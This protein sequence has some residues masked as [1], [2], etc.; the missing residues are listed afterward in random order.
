[1]RKLHR[2][3]EEEEKRRLKSQVYFKMRMR[4]GF[5]MPTKLTWYGHGCWA[6]ESSGYHVLIDPFLNDSPVAPVKADQ[7]AADYILISHGHFDHIADAA[8]IAQRTGAKVVAIYE[9]AQWL[10]Q[11]HGIADTI[12]MNL[13]G[14]VRL[15]FG[16]VKMTLA[17]HSS[18]LPDGSYGGAPV[19]FL[20]TVEE[21]KLYFACDTALFQDMK[22]IGE[23]G[24]TV[25]VLPIGDMFTMGPEDALKA[26]QWLRP[27][28][29]LPSHYDTW[30]PIAQDAQA[31]ADRVR[32]VTPAEPIIVKPGE[33]WTVPA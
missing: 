8:A 27:R 22:L 23:E 10:S 3:P 29:V 30:P 32:S 1:M 9:I 2:Y 6:L 12:G 11:K 31:W 20:L 18:Q 5:V 17:Y 7:V 14:S 24:L 19:G 15:P 16:R 25:A 28:Y 33:S 4:R 21:G 26:V 13:G